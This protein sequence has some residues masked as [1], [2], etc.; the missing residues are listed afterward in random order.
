MIRHLLI[1]VPLL[2]GSFPFSISTLYS[3]HSRG[4]YPWLRREG[5]DGERGKFLWVDTVAFDEWASNKGKAYRFH[6]SKEDGQR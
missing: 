6:S 3:G 1:P 5:P 2:G 4:R